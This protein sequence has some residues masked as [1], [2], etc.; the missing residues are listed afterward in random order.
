M[1]ADY[2]QKK[3]II[4]LAFILSLMD[5]RRKLLKFKTMKKQVLFLTMFIIA[6]LAGSSNAFGQALDQHISISQPITPLSC[7]AGTPLPLHPFAGIAYT[8]TMTAPGAEAVSYTHLTLPTTP[9][10]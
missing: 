2:S 8:Y 6:V 10:V 1:D 7:A 4:N 5:G 3:Q 9:Y